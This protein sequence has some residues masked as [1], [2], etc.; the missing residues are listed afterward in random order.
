MQPK[1]TVPC[2]PCKGS[3][4]IPHIKR[5]VGPEGAKIDDPMDFAVIDVCERCNGGGRMSAPPPP[6]TG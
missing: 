4:N 5:Q 6:S 1:P 2:E 3:G